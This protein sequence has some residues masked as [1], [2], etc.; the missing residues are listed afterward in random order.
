MQKEE[1]IHDNL[2]SYLLN[3]NVVT[4]FISGQET[5]TAYKMSQILYEYYKNLYK[6]TSIKENKWFQF[7]NNDWTELQARP[8]LFNE[9]TNLKASFNFL[10]AY[11]AHK[12]ATESDDLR[13]MKNIVE[14]LGEIIRTFDSVA[15]RNDIIN[16]CKQLFYDP[17]IV[18]NV[19]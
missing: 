2:P 17:N 10:R 8:I 7:T 4:E 11:Y 18:I 9:I 1:Q 6:C 19:D 3:N 13:N 15:F 5:C 16:E 12:C 14:K